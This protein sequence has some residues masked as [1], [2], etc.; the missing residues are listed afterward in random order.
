[1]TEKKV[2]VEV[3]TWYDG[4]LFWYYPQTGGWEYRR[5]ND[6]AYTIANERK[7]DIERIVKDM[8]AE[9]QEKAYKGWDSD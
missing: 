4:V 7:D 1:M 8:Y 3:P 2:G 6:R 5:D 9:D